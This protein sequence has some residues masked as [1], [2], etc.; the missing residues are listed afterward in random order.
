MDS[1]MSGR[2]RGRDY[3]A[4]F[5]RDPGKILVPGN[6]GG[7]ACII[8]VSPYNQSNFLVFYLRKYIIYILLVYSDMK[9]QRIEM[10]IQICFFILEIYIYVSFRLKKIYSKR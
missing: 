10:E 5:R 8:Q 4:N 3:R 1:E 9:G 6:L 2:H 7:K